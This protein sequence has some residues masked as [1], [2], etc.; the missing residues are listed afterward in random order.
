MSFPDTKLHMYLCRYENSFSGS[1]IHSKV[2]NFLPGC[3]NYILRYKTSYPG[4]IITYWGM[5]LLTR[6][7]NCLWET[8]L[9]V[10]K[11]IPLGRYICPN[12]TR[13]YVCKDA[14]TRKILSSWDFRG[15]SK[16]CRT[17]QKERLL[18]HKLC[19]TTQNERPLFTKSAVRHKIRVS[20]KQ[21]FN[22]IPVS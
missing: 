15:I 1:K 10:L 13:V 22:F 5:K 16:F 4:V 21:T 3:K 19:R 6:V 12:V 17:T 9:S 7:Q 11:C 14:A 2:W 8:D 18:F 20:S